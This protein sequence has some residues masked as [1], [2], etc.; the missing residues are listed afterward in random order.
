MN[1]NL[2]V[3][4]QIQPFSKCHPY[5]DFYRLGSRMLTKFFKVTQCQKII[6]LGLESI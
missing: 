5:K 3:S 1:G 2:G 4:S 6:E